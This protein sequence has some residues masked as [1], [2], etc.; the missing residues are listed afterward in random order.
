[1]WDVAYVLIT[2][3]FFAAMLWY[4][5]GCERLGTHTST[6]SRDDQPVGGWRNGPK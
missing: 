4:V 3:F 6:E 1:M 5:G 2:M